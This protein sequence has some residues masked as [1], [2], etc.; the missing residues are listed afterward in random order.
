MSAHTTEPLQFVRDPVSDE[1]LAR[2]NHYALISRLFH[3]APD[4]ALLDMMAASGDWLIDEDA[5]AVEAVRMA[6]A[7]NAL[8]SA[9]SAMDA[10]A[11]GLEFD[12]LFGGVGRPA[13]TVFGSFYLAGFVNEKPLAA[14]RGDLAEL[15]FARAQGEA[16]PEDHI[17]AVC[18]VMR[19]L[20]TDASR[21]AADRAALQ[22]R[23]FARHIQPWCGA[24]CDAVEAAAGANFYRRVSQY[25]RCFFE[26]EKAALS[27]DP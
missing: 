24:L 16:L 26:V 11:A 15:G 27:I 4:D 2:A 3:A 9:C 7:W 22:D 13:V 8:C 19:L 6:E 18:D 5:P 20:L 10:E 1:D 21:T 23:F 14:L 25:A 17:A 12:A